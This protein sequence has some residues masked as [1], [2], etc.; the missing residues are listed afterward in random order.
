MLAAAAAS[1][2]RSPAPWRRRSSRCASS[3][4][5]RRCAGSAVLK[6]VMSEARPT[7]LRISPSSSNSGANARQGPTHRPVHP[8]DLALQVAG[9]RGRLRAANLLAQQVWCILG[10]SA[11]RSVPVASGAVRD[12]PPPE[13]SARSVQSALIE[14]RASEE[15]RISESDRAVRTAMLRS[16]RW[17]S[18]ATASRPTAPARR[19]ARRCSPAARRRRSAG[20][21]RGIRGRRGPDGVH[22]GR[23]DRMAASRRRRCSP[24]AA[25][26]SPPAGPDSGCAGPP[27]RRRLR[28]RVVPRHPGLRTRHRRRPLSSA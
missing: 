23:Q 6:S 8:V 16:R 24:R 18:P 15:E 21:R 2:L 11:L 13:S 4:F 26:R 12:N 27:P 10:N 7:W 17:A 22:S 19:C 20:G 5:G 1:G 14:Q 3:S 25:P 28:R 9:R